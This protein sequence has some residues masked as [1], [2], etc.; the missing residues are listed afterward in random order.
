MKQYRATLLAF[1]VLVATLPLSGCGD[2]EDYKDAATITLKTST[3]SVAVKELAIF[4]VT[5]APPAEGFDACATIMQ[6]SAKGAG[7]DLTW[8]QLPRTDTTQIFEVRPRQVG[9]LSVVARARCDSSG[10]N[11]QYSDQVDVTVTETTLPQVRSVT[12]TA[13]PNPYTVTGGA[14][15]NFTLGA[16]ADAGCTVKLSY[17]YTGGGLP[18]TTV[19]PATAGIF[20]LNPNNASLG[21]LT[22]LATGWCAENSS[23]IASSP[24]VNVVLNP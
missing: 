5:S 9:T 4:T 7:M 3:Q 16:T 17:Q 8:A 11:W 2:P 1:A 14:G 19:N 18:A 12:L 22:V 24:T 13:S 21:P 20:T 23:V 6:Y 15:V 10:Q